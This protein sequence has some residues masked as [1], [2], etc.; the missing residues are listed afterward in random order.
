MSSETTLPASRIFH[1][2]LVV[3][4]AFAVT[5]VGFGCAYTFSAFVEPLQRDFAASRGSVSTPLS[6]NPCIL[7][8]STTAITTSEVTSASAHSIS[9]CWGCVFARPVAA[10]PVAVGS[11]SRR[12][13]PRVV[14]RSFKC[15]TAD[16]RARSM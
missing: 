15:W 12:P 10:R 13:G 4:A 6:R 3:A 7:V 1:G 11:T 2:W 8:F 16:R 9:S 5:F 14:G